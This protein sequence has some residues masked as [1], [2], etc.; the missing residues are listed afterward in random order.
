MIEWTRKR[1]ASYT[2][3][4]RDLFRLR[5]IPRRWNIGSIYH[6]IIQIGFLFF[7]RLD[8]CSDMRK[9]SWVEGTIISEQRV[10]PTRT[11]GLNRL[12]F[13][14]FLSSAAIAVS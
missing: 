9:Y 5:V 8:D 14:F 13:L 1:E 2:F 4:A 12:R 3:Q 7:A 10:I 11:S 6:W